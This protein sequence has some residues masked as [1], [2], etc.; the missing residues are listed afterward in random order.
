MLKVHYMAQL[1]RFRIRFIFF[2]R[3][4]F[5]SNSVKLQDLNEKRNRGEKYYFS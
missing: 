3:T 2:Q 4:A 5:S 1:L